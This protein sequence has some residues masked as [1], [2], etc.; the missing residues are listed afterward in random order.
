MEP[1]LLKIPEVAARLGLSRAKVY[2]LMSRG[3]LR[4]VRV[5]GCRRVRTE[6]L[7]TFVAS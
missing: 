4:S 7:V 3:A 5:D 6:D 2:E 1:M